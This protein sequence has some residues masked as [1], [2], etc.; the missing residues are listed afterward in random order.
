V[1]QGGNQQQQHST[2]QQD[3]RLAQQQ[4]AA[5]SGAAAAAA[6]L[7][8][9]LAPSDILQQAGPQQSV[10][11]SEPHP[12]PSPHCQANPPAYQQQEWQQQHLGADSNGSSAVCG[13]GWTAD[14]GGAAAA[15]IGAA[16]S[17][18][19]ADEVLSAVVE[20][21]ARGAAGPGSSVAAP[22][23]PSESGSLSEPATEHGEQWSQAQPEWVSWDAYSKLQGKL[24]RAKVQF[25]EM[26][27]A[28]HKSK[29]ANR[30]LKQQLA[31]SRAQ[32]GVL[33]E[34]QCVCVMVAVSAVHAGSMSHT[35]CWR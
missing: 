19:W 12:L 32:V 6:L 10:V 18:A 30:E 13:F 34:R 15:G 29:D 7:L 14:P 22:P 20:E 11:H 1:Q 2:D 4:A 28:H 25:F 17:G 23:R 24:E 8:R 9:D 5:D 16:G 3:F 27:A 33:C 21:V 31:A 35:C 26:K